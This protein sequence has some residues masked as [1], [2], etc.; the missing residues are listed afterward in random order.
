MLRIQEL[1]GL[2]ICWLR[3][4]QVCFESTL[5]VNEHSPCNIVARYDRAARPLCR[6]LNREAL[7]TEMLCGNQKFMPCSY[8]RDRLVKV[9]APVTIFEFQAME[10]KGA[11]LATAITENGAEN[12]FGPWLNELERM[13]RSLRNAGQAHDRGRWGVCVYLHTLWIFAAD[14]EGYSSA[15]PQLAGHVD[16]Y[17]LPLAM[18]TEQTGALVP[19]PAE[20]SVPA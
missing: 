4:G 15:A 7:L 14:E 10:T 12:V 11:R 3:P 20:T 17:R 18:F 16:L 13:G 2:R 8:G 5:G 1:C 9:L 19:V 6:R